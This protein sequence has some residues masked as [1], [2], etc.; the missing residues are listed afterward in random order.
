MT[1]LTRR[2]IAL[3]LCASILVGSASLA[4]AQ[5]C[6]G[7]GCSQSQSG[8]PS[9]ALSTGEGL[10]RGDRLTLPFAG[11]KFILI[12]AKEE[13]LYCDLALEAIIRDGQLQ[14][15]GVQIV[16]VSRLPFSRAYQRRIQGRY[17]DTR[18][19]TGNPAETIIAGL[20]TSTMPSLTLLN[21]GRVE[22]MWR[23]FD[24]ALGPHVVS[25]VRALARN[26]S[27]PNGL[28]R[29]SYGQQLLRAGSRPPNVPVNGWTPINSPALVLVT[30]SECPACTTLHPAIRSSLSRSVALGVDV[31]VIDTASNSQVRSARLSFM[32]RYLS[33]RPSSEAEAQVR[34]MTYDHGV[35]AF[36]D[37]WTSV[38]LVWGNLMTPTVYVFGK[39]GALIDI[40]KYRGSAEIDTYIRDIQRTILGAR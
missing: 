4:N 3:T 13:C 5:A 17:R 25:G 34:M 15:S 9:N 19:V 14:R 24:P 31:R 40:M 10:S 33:R 27:L 28:S 22:A 26:G 29:A 8:S 23:G 39:N 2:R 36:R 21:Q 16:L 20:N 1:A 11:E 38:N 37:P 7:Q 32:D 6:T 18:F 30:S 35:K 12:H